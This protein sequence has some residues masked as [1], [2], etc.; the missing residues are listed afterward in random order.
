M[1]KSNPLERIIAATGLD[2]V[3]DVESWRAHLVRVIEWAGVVAMPL[4]LLASMPVY[5]R[6][7]HLTLIIIDCL[8]WL[9]L[10][11]MV[12][13]PPESIRFR[14]LVTLGVVFMLSV[15]FLVTLGPTHARAAWPV[16]FVALASALFG[17]RGTVVAT[18]LNAGML[19]LVYLTASPEDPAWQ[20]TLSEPTN[21]WSMFV[22]SLS[23]LS[24]LTGIP[25]ALLLR[26]L[27]RTLNKERHAR[28][29]LSSERAELERAYGKL[30][31]EVEERQ[32]LERRVQQA[33]KLEAIGQ[34]AGGIAHDLNN[35][36]MPIL[37]SAELAQLKLPQDSPVQGRLKDI[38]E[39]GERARALVQQILLFSREVPPDRQLVDIGE[40]LSEVAR[41]VDRTLPEGIELQLELD[42]APLVLGNSVALFQ[43][44]LNLVTNAV[45]AMEGHQ[46]AIT[47]RCLQV[48]ADTPI[49]DPQANRESGREYACVVVEDQGTG[50]DAE[51]A[52][53]VFEPF[54]TTKPFGQGTG[55][56]LATTHGIVNAYGGQIT[57]RTE[58]DAG[59]AFSVYL[60]TASTAQRRQLEPTANRTDDRPSSV[61]RALLVD[62]NPHTRMTISRQLESLGYDV[63]EAA[64]A[65]DALEQFS[66]ADDDHRSAPFQLVITDLHM[67]DMTGF[68]LCS[69][70]KQDHPGLPVLLATGFSEHNTQREAK[71]AGIDSIISKPFSRQD[72]DRALTSL[73]PRSR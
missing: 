24:F 5:L 22:V 8:V 10:V 43:V 53:R 9:Y 23:L 12:L 62:D 4:G 66:A 42:D 68:E 45:A 18:L 17:A 56:G 34:L 25:V 32:R 63:V 48:A 59:T 11:V 16:L 55:L 33:E 26:G 57:L 14:S 1:N 65:T 35:V 60:P 30:Q 52:S 49:D 20:H 44:V 40:V 71:Q 72:L 27:D 15:T 41:D 73:M 58:P 39:A 3:T 37:G 54:F 19:T 36:L 31:L 38:L 2:Q 47:L 7:Q 28:A 69:A 70:I 67:P 64:D 50:M 51:T 29:Q 6:E 21:R 46:G 13:R 61:G